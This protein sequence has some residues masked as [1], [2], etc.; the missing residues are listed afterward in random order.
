MAWW[1]WLLLAYLP[2]SALLAVF[3]GRAIDL[4]D[5]R[6]KTRRCSPPAG[7]QSRIKRRPVARQSMASP[8]MRRHLRSGVGEQPRHNRR[9]V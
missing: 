5:R 1:G 7:L 4:A 9:R 3:L 6:E 2:V 8:V